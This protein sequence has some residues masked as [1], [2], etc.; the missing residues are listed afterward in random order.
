MRSNKYYCRHCHIVNCQY[1]TSISILAN[2]CELGLHGGRPSKGVC[3]NCIS[4]GENTLEHSEKIKT[5]PPSISQQATTF[6]KSLLNW[7][8]IGFYNTPTDILANREAICS[9]CHEWDA[10]ALNKTGRCKKC[11]CSTWVKIRMST[12]R[13]PLGKWEAI[14]KILE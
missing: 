12:E 2:S 1:A 5:N 8:S 10:N 11:G 4:N 14:E 13:C 9:S 7:A 3:F 6:G